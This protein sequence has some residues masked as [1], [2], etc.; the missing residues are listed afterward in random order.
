MLTL[1]ELR[2]DREH[3]SFSSI[4]SFLNICSLQW[5]FQRVYR[6][7]REFIPSAL[8]FGSVFHRVAEYIY[9]TF[10][11]GAPCPSSTQAGE[12]FGDLWQRQLEED[13]GI[14][15]DEEV[16]ADDCCQEGIKLAGCLADN[17]NRDERVLDVNKT[18][19]V[20]LINAEGVA[21]ETPII[22]EIDWVS[23]DEA[24][25]VFL[26]DWKS[27]KNRWPKKKAALD[28]QPTCSLYAW[29]QVQRSCP[30][31]R[32]QVV[33]KQVKPVCEMHITTRKPEDFARLVWLVERIELAVNA[34]LFFPS[35]QS[36]YCAGCGFKSAC[37][38]WH[39]KRRTVT[40][41]A[42]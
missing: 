38:Q 20:P 4:N 28:L 18:F 13:R 30:E 16:S 21:L 11:S 14:R 22:G 19:A 35:E 8:V 7:E 9:L 29:N 1:E 31:F 12:M 40:S 5:A 24:G 33:V 41:V 27:S 23:Q 6:I 37:K 2:T 10:K 42:A 36:F 17:L 26:N 32:F 25:L 34:E 15:F 39:R 3:W